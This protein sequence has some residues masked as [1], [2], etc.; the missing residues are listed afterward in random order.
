MARAEGWIEIEIAWSLRAGEVLRRSLSLP[1]GSTIA[2]A[3]AQSGLT[4]PQD[5]TPAVWGKPREVSET[6]CDQDRLELLRPLSA[7][8]KEARRRRLRQTGTPG[9]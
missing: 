2:E 5:W 9:T 1:A 8:P 7:D 3:I 4:L 6:L